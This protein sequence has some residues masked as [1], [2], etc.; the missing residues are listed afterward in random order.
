VHSTIDGRY[1][2]IEH[3]D[4]PRNVFFSG[5]ALLPG[6]RVSSLIKGQS[7]S[8]ELEENLSEDLSRFKA[9]SVWP[10]ESDL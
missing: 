2:F 9:K 10:S 3:K 5:A 6:I 4:Y 8:F 1:G 7:V